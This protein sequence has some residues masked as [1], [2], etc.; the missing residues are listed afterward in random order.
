MTDRPHEPQQLLESLLSPKDAPEGAPATPARADENDEDVDVVIDDL[1]MLFTGSKRMPFGR[2]LLVDEDQA[3]DL[4]DRLRS[5][6]PAEVRQAHRVLDEKERI[7]D[8]AREEARRMLHERGLMAELEIERERMMTAAEREAE[9]IR[10]DADAYVRGV[11]ND[12][13]ERL[14]KIQASVRAGIDALNPPNPPPES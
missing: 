8:G 6:V 14:T 1:E 4:V 7:L 2:R 12:V 3:L 10:G 9:R 5:A 13:G 11:L